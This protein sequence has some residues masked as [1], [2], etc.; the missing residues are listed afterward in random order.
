MPPKLLRARYGF[1]TM[2]R[3]YNGLDVD[4][5]NNAGFGMHTL[6]THEHNGHTP[7]ESVFILLLM[8]AN[9]CYLGRFHWGFLLSRTVLGLCLANGFGRV[10]RVD[11]INFFSQRMW[12]IY[13]PVCAFLCV[14]ACVRG[15]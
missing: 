7:A 12:R 5:Q 3:H 14:S 15:F 6:S 9:S 8:L 13:S 11:L 1:P 2:M 10:V 4:I